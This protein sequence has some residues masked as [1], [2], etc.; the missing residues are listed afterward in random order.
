M[1]HHI[2]AVWV[3]IALADSV[4]PDMLRLIPD[5]L[6]CELSTIFFAVGW[7]MR[8]TSYRTSSMIKLLEIMFDITF[9]ITRCVNLPWSVYRCWHVSTEIG[10]ARFTLIPIVLMQWFWMFKIIQ[11]VVN[12]KKKNIAIEKK[13]VVKK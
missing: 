13:E 4:S 5:I 9:F 10:F 8:S 1:I 2:L 11:S 12:P 3:T 6:L 7:I